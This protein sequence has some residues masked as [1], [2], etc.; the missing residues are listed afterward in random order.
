MGKARR[1]WKERV[2]DDFVP[3]NVLTVKK[4]TEKLD[5]FQIPKE[6]D[7][8]NDS[9]LLNDNGESFLAEITYHDISPNKTV[10]NKTWA[11]INRSSK[12]D[13]K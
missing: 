10:K 6:E 11:D 1:T 2:I 4:I 3:P 7:L 8:M 9:L 12:F 13:S 5:Q